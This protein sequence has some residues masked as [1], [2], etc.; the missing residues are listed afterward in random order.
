[1]EVRS[2]GVVEVRKVQMNPLEEFCTAR[3]TRWKRGVAVVEKCRAQLGGREFRRLL[4]HR[5]SSLHEWDLIAG[6]TTDVENHRV[7]GMVV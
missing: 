6:G 1:M 7:H 5:Q 3:K 4:P 2:I